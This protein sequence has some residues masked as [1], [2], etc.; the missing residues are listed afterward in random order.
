[1]EIGCYSRNIKLS[2]PHK[3]FS[4]NNGEEYYGHERPYLTEIQGEGGVGGHQRPY[5]A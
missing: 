2:H 5:L 4:Y 3:V 1:M